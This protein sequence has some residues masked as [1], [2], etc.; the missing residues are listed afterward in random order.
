MATTTTRNAGEAIREAWQRGT[1]RRD[2]DLLANLYTQ[3]C[4]HVIINRNS[5]PSRPTV[6]KGR[7]AMRKMFADVFAREMTHCLENVVIGEDR[8]AFHKSCQYPDGTRVVL[9]TIAELRDGKIFRE[10]AVDCWD[11]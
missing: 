1:D 10:T 3:D 11:E 9:L 7:D 5:P 6:L 2:P 4:E 8:M